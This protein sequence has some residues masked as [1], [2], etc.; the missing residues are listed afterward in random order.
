[1]AHEMKVGRDET[2]IEAAFARVTARVRAHLDA[3]ATAT[4]QV[5]TAT[6]MAQMMAMK[7]LN[8]G[9]LADDLRYGSSAF[10]VP[11]GGG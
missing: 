8:L 2:S 11:K 6:I 5:D 4:T 3:M 10:V 7:M 1:M 9:Q